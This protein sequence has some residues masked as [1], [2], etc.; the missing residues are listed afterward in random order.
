MRIQRF[1]E[2]SEIYGA[3]LRRWPEAE[4]GTAEEVARNSVEAAAVLAR[5]AELD[6]FLDMSRV[7][8]PSAALRECIVGAAPV[9]RRL[10]LASF[11]WRGLGLAGMGLA[12]AATGM[13]LAG[14]L[15]SARP[16]D[17]D[18]YAMTAFGTPFDQGEVQ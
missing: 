17:E 11:I 4:R 1:T 12:G 14:L 7:S 9:R 8:A 15:V 16:L 2:L 13:M 3:D 6:T 10:S 5:A 18:T